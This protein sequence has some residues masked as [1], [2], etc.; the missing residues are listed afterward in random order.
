MRLFVDD[1]RIPLQPDAWTVV[2]TVNDAKKV[3]ET[4]T[5]THLVLDHDLG[6]FAADGGDVIELVRWLAEC[7]VWDDPHWPSEGIQIVSSNPIG[8]QAMLSLIDTY[9]PYTVGAGFVRGDFTGVDV[10]FTVPDDPQIVDI[11]GDGN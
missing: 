8:A 5:V 4:N 1:R 6:D 10:S 9:G 2:K 7:S 11:S 3:L